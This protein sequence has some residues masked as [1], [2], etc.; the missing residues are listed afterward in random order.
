MKTNPFRY[1]SAVGECWV[2]TMFKVKYCHRVFDDEKVRACADRLFKEA[3]EKY[4]IRC[5]TI[6]FDCDHVHMTIDLGLRSKPQVAKL[7]KGYTGAK[8]LKEFP[9]MQKKLFWGGGFWNPS[10]YI[11]SSRGLE[12]ITK[13]VNKQKY[14]CVTLTQ[15][16]HQTRLVAF[17]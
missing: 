4:R 2:H 17:A 1:S 16:N 3:F 11:D 14:G 7:L 15:D 10:Y 6:G 9:T 8:I 5:G 12:T 13:Y